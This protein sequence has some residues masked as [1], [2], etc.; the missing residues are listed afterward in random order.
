MYLP[1]EKTNLCCYKLRHVL[2][3]ILFGFAV[4]VH[5]QSPH[6]SASKLND[7]MKSV[8][9]ININE[10]IPIGKQGL[11][12]AQQTHDTLMLAAISQN[13]AGTFLMMGKYDSAAIYA[14][15]AMAWYRFC[16]DEMEML[17]CRYYLGISY[18]LQGLYSESID[19]CQ[20]ILQ[21]PY[22]DTSSRLYSFVLGELG[23]VYYRQSLYGKSVKYYSEARPYF[24]DD[25]S[26]FISASINLGAALYALGIHDSSIIVLQEGLK[27]AEKSNWRLK[28]AALLTNLS[29]NWQAL[30]RFNDAITC[31]DE[32]IMIR[33]ESE[34]SLGLS[35]SY[36]SKG[37]ILVAKGAYNLASDYYFRSLKIDESLNIPDNI[38][39]TYC[40]IGRCL[41]YKND[42]EAAMAYFEQGYDIAVKVGAG[43]A[44]EAALK[45]M[46]LSSMALHNTKQAIDFMERYIT[47]HD[48]IVSVDGGGNNLVPANTSPS[49][50]EPKNALKRLATFLGISLLICTV[51]LLLYR[52]RNLRTAL[53]RDADEKNI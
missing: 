24:V 8:R 44:I 19:E 37:N 33:E 34:D 11:Q 35:Y 43:A 45:G 25:T 52:N 53:K 23:N 14:Q 30:G 13:I 15:E 9:K 50:K 41:Q 4:F 38:A 1:T 5:A 17:W 40:S 2:L 36:R 47:V 18:S 26:R 3:L 48:S 12:I 51:I 32:A 16:E 28:K 39:A 22:I 42:H 10:A 7:S 49:L 31:I 27:Y 20:Q 6:I 46:A 29:D 21:S